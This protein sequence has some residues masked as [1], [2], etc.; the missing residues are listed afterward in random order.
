MIFLIDFRDFD[1]QVRSEFFKER[2]EQF[3]QKFPKY[4]KKVK[5]VAKG[6]GENF[7]VAGY[8]NTLNDFCGKCSV[9]SETILFCYFEVIC[10]IFSFKIYLI[11]L[12][13]IYTVG[14]VKSTNLKSTSF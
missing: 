10:G 6:I 3:F 14:S 1:L 9:K 8:V 5:K 7:P 11:M 13:F 12:K 4:Q 2:N